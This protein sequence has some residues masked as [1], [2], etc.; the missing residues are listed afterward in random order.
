MENVDGVSYNEAKNM[1][2]VQ[3]RGGHR[4]AYQPV[5]PENYAEIVKSNCLSEVIHKTTRQLNVVGIAQQR[6][7]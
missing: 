2:I 1:L 4:V 6:G 5:N 3:Y 7:H